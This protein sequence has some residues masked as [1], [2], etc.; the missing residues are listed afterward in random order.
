M[1]T[2]HI[3]KLKVNKK[4]KQKLNNCLLFKRNKAYWQMMIMSISQAMKLRLNKSLQ[5]NNSNK[6]K[7][8]LL[9]KEEI[10]LMMS[11]SQLMK[12]HLMTIT[13]I[14]LLSLR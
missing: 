4:L 2:I 7:A 9:R 8:L 1:L 3:N 12:V 10:Y 13:L 5:N 11:Q 6:N 14:T